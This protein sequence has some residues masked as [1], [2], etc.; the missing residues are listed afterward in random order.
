M[1][2]LVGFL[3]IIAAGNVWADCAPEK[4]VKIVTRDV[5]PAVA[6]TWAA[7]PKTLYRWGTHYARLEETPDTKNG[8]HGLLVSN[9]RDHWMVN[10][11]T[12]TG[13]HIVDTADS[14]DTHAPILGRTGSPLVELEFGCELE[15][16]KSQGIKP[17]ETT[18]E[19]RSFL[20]YKVEADG[21]AIHL[22]VDPHTEQPWAVEV[23]ENHEPTV[24]IRYDSYE[25]GLKPDPA[26]FE[27]PAG[28]VYTDAK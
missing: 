26:L 21:I 10:L 16:M 20:Q 3:L 12:S 4:M 13:Q 27:R 23:L 17:V 28:I 8:I 2:A 15:F 25:A 5:R 24:Q 19:N 11:T 18:V 14:F 9:N 7:A 22:L 6:G 1:R